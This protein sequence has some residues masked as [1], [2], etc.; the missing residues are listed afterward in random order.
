MQ[1]TNDPPDPDTVQENVGEH[2]DFAG[3]LAPAHFFAGGRRFDVEYREEANGVWYA[4][5]EVFRAKN[6]VLY[7]PDHAKFPLSGKEEVYSEEREGATP[8]DAFQALLA[9]VQ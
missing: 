1:K 6:G 9:I 5:T 8:G 4:S 7:H 3:G 2:S